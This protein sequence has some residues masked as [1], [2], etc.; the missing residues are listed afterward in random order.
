[1]LRYLY[2]TIFNNDM[3]CELRQ[4]A[5]A[6]RMTGYSEKFHLKVCCLGKQQTNIYM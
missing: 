4:T 5:T 1:M 2:S 3:H 6:V